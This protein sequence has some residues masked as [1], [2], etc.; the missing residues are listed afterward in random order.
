MQKWLG[1]IAALFV[2]FIWGT[3]FVSSKVLLNEG[4][5]PDEI[6]FCRGIIASFVGFVLWN[7]VLSQID[8]IKAT[9]YVYLQS[10]I[11]LVVA[12][13]I[14]GESITLMAVAGM[15]ILI[16]GMVLAQKEK[17]NTESDT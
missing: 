9:N 17:A 5:S 2:V 10:F 3:T 7:W 15:I 6:F 13:I 11:T 8:T 4:L 16:T 1:H 14:L 12:A